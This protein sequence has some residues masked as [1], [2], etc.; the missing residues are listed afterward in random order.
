MRESKLLIIF[1][2]DGYNT[3]GCI[4]CC[5]IMGIPM[6]V[7]LVCN[8]WVCP[9]LSSVYVKRYKKVRSEQ[10]GLEELFAQREEWKGS[11]ILPTSDTAEKVLGDNA[12]KLRP[13]Y[14]FPYSNTKCGINSLMYKNKQ[15]DLAQKAGLNVPQT[16]FFSKDDPIPSAVVYPCIIKQA[17]S[18]EG[19]KQK[20]AVCRNKD[21]LIKELAKASHTTE[22]VIQQ[23]I[24][25][26][27][28]LLLI[29]CRLPDGSTIIPGVFKKERWYF[30]GNDASYGVISTDV[31]KYFSQLDAVGRLMESMEYFGPFSIEFGVVDDIPYFYE[32]NLRND[33]TSHYFH[34]AGIFIPYLYYKAFSEADFVIPMTQ[35]SE[36]RFIDEFGDA[37]N[38]VS[39]KLSFLR[40]FKDLT[41]ASAFKYYSK[42]DIKP[43]VLM[44][45]RRFAATI[46][47]MFFS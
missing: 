47:H 19:E 32:V 43:F 39:T 6:F 42:D 35:K 2:D 45:P 14:L 12:I 29:G 38:I 24:D 23:Y 21:N 44:F 7:L 27:Y 22:F 3:L 28:E 40:W 16:F 5:G 36:Y 37:V 26:K 34:K 41:S 15:V 25:R 33:G 30:K 9:T 31:N 11:I 20:L 10:A 17:N 46:Y 18:V 4:R 8:S 13:Y 1:G